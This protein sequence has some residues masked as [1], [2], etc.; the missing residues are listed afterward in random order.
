MSAEL[1]TRT[2]TLKSISDLL[3]EYRED[4]LGSLSHGLAQVVEQATFIHRL[5]R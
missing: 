2:E 4:Y 5:Q 3:H 1:G